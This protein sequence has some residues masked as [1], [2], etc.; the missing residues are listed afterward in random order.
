M[1]SL[2]LYLISKIFKQTVLL[3]ILSKGF[4]QSLSLLYRV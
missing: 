2:S 1:Y 3:F 4:V